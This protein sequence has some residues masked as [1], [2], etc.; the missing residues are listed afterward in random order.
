MHV[1]KQRI[2]YYFHWI[3]LAVKWFGALS[4]RVK[5]NELAFPVESLAG[6]GEGFIKKPLKVLIEQ[7]SKHPLIL[8]FSIPIGR[9]KEI[10]AKMIQG[11]EFKYK[12]RKP[13]RKRFSLREAIEKKGGKLD[14]LS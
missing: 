2:R 3:L 6:G 7:G 5:I 13:R 8:I 10:S 4:R 11:G 14:S 9:R 12:R 1:K